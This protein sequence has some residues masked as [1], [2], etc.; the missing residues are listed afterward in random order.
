MTAYE[1][2]KIRRRRICTT[3]LG[4]TAVSLGGCLGVGAQDELDDFGE[5]EYTV[6]IVDRSDDTVVAD[7]HGH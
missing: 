4:A 6:N 2:R 3:V 1:E 5:E 7:Y